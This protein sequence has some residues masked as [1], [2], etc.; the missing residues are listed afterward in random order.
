[1]H[2]KLKNRNTAGG[3]TLLEAL[4]AVMLIGLVIAALAVSSGAFTMANAAAVDLSTAEFL[5][6]EIR[7]LTAM[8]PFGDLSGLAG[9]YPTPIDVTET[10]LTDFAAFEQQV[11]VDPCGDD[12][13]AP[14]A[15][16]VRITVK[17]LKNDR[18]ISEASWIR[19]DLD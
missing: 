7:E 11:A 5:I 12:F 18:P 16:F 14:T 13:N 8:T 4:F 15:D 2:T 1:M 9:N 3:F 10:P 6:E 17:I 19:A